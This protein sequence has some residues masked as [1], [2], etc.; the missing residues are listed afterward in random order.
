MRLIR[1]MKRIKEE[2][3]ARDAFHKG[4]ETCLGRRGSS[5]CVS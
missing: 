3:V 2:E 1:G 4:A 5:E